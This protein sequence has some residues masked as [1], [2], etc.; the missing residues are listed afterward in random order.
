MPLSGKSPEFTAVI[1][2]NEVTAVVHRKR[3]H[4]TKEPEALDPARSRPWS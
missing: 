4:E 2:T 1:S 3:E